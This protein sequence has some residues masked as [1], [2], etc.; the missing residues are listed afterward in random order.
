MAEAQKSKMPPKEY[1]Y[2]TFQRLTNENWGNGQSAAVRKRLQALNI[3]APPGS[4]QAN[5][6]LQQALLDAEKS[7]TLAPPAP[8][9]VAQA[10]LARR[11]PFKDSW[12]WEAET[13]ASE[14]NAGGWLA[15]LAAKVAPAQTRV[16]LSTLLGNRAP[17]TNKDFAPSELRQLEKIVNQNP[18]GVGSYN[19]YRISE[20]TGPRGTDPLDVTTSNPIRKAVDP[21]LAMAQT[22]GRFSAPTID[23]VTGERI[24]TDTYDFDN[25]ARAASINRYEQAREKWGGLGVVASLLRNLAGRGDVGSAFNALPS[26]IANAYIGRHGR[27]VRIVLPPKNPLAND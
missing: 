12:R 1:P 20:G 17:L 24:V 11:V 19:A 3:T 16:Y 6:A 14:E 2:Q 26:E 7:G 25:P 21:S 10:V 18:G 23:P 9:R 27:P 22:L 4:A 15:D 8:N 5:K 13:P